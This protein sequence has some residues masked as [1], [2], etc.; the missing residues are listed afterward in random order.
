MD[1]GN[2]LICPICLDA[3]KLSEADCYDSCACTSVFHEHCLK[4]WLTKNKNEPKCPVCRLGDSSSPD[5]IIRLCRE[6]CVD[7]S[8]LHCVIKSSTDFHDTYAKFV[9]K[10][11]SPQMF[12]KLFTDLLH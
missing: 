3:V 4:R 2:N 5:D 9:E 10:G 6:Y 11:W 7:I 12:I 8:E 1:S